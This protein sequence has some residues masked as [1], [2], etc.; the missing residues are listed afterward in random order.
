M[1]DGEVY[2]FVEWLAFWW[3]KELSLV[4]IRQCSGIGQPRYLERVMG[5]WADPESRQLHSL[6]KGMRESCWDFGWF[7]ES[8]MKFDRAGKASALLVGKEFLEDPG[9]EASRSEVGAESQKIGGMGFSRHEKATRSEQSV[10]APTLVEL[11]QTIRKDQ[12]TLQILI[13]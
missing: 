12:R 13:A 9:L 8:R 4:V 1:C 2:F 5:G 7:G 3:G 11:F 10:I 6:L